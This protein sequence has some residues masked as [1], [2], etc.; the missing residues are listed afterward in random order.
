MGLFSHFRS[1][2]GRNSDRTPGGGLIVLN[3]NLHMNVQGRTGA[4]DQL[5]QNR[6]ARLIPAGPQQRR[7][8]A[9]QTP[10]M[11]ETEAAFIRWARRTPTIEQE[12]AAGKSA[13]RAAV[14]G[15]RLR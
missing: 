8:I 14:N 3:F 5:G 13:I 9:A 12:L 7:V 6:S 1:L 11:N 15:A 10:A 4:I 2:F